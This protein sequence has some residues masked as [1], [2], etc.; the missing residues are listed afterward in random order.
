MLFAGMGNLRRSLIIGALALTLAAPKPAAHAQSQTNNPQKVSETI[1]DGSLIQTRNPFKACDGDCR[2]TLSFGRNVDTPMNDIFFK[3]VAPWDWKFGDVYFASATAG[4]PVL[5][6]GDYISIEPEIGLGKR[7]GDAHEF[8]IWGAI[9]LRWLKFPWNNY[10]VTT[11]AVSTGLNYATGIPDAERRT[12][13]RSG[14]DP[15]QL[16]HYF[17]PEITLALPKYPNYSMEIRLHHRSAAGV[18]G[19]FAGLQYLMFGVRRQF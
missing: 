9:Y 15:S 16:L 5:T 14:G 2:F 12:S 6:I 3:P 11:V 19:N 17:S 1:E 7:F 18:F 10:V 4:R 13:G 8:E